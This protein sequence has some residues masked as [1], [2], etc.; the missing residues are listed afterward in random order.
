MSLD[1]NSAKKQPNGV[2]TFRLRTRVRNPLNGTYFFVYL[3]RAIDCQTMETVSI[4]DG[5]REGFQPW[6]GQFT[7]KTTFSQ[8]GYRWF[9]E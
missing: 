1:L 9:C 6:V 3:S 7:D 5:K 4:V 2:T 8:M